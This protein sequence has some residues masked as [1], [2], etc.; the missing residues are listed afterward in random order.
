MD[1]YTRLVLE[2]AREARRGERAAVARPQAAP[3]APRPASQK[4]VERLDR[5]MEELRGKIEILDKALTDAEIFS[6]E[7]KKAADFGKLRA[8]LAGELEEL[9]NQWLEAQIG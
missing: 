8:R 2:K 1:D 5:K 3:A 7:P 4:A 6:K 9:E